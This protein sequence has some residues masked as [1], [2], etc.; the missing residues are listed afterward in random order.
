MPQASGPD[1]GLR[2]ARGL[3]AIRTNSTRVCHGRAMISSEFSL[4][5]VLCALDIQ[6]C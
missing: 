4:R 2:T 6:F 1:S 5:L 3:V